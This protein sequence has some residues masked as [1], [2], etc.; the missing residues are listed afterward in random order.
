MS[1][2]IKVQ[3]EI[4][5]GTTREQKTKLMLALAELK[6]DKPVALDGF[7]SLDLIQDML[8]LNIPATQVRY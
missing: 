3:F 5:Q 8:H 6:L 4:P 7:G 2:P 1:F